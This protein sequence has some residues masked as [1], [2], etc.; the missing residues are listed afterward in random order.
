MGENAAIKI[1]RLLFFCN[2]KNEN[3]PMKFRREE[4]WSRK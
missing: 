2:K 3:K 4:L 1:D